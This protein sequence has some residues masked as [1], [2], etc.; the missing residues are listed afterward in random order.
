[1]L[2][3]G[4]GGFTFGNDIYFP[5]GFYDPQS[6]IGISS[7]CHELYHVS[8]FNRLGKAGFIKEYIDSYVGNI[9]EQVDSQGNPFPR[10]PE[11]LLQPTLDV[12]GWKAYEFIRWLMK[13]K[14]WMKKGGN[15]VDLNKAY[16][17]ISLEKDAYEFESQMRIYLEQ[18]ARGR[19]DKP[20]A[21]GRFYF[22]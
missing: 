9:E 1:M 4:V 13:F 8:Q 11:S 22:C 16:E 19:G 6:H 15:K 7:I 17:D 21:N 20:D 2:K 14:E 12:T 5:N 10:I 3:N 18:V